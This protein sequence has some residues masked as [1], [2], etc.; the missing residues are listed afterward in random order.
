MSRIR[1]GLPYLARSSKGTFYPSFGKSNAVIF[2]AEAYKRYQLE[3]IS[4]LLA[5]VNQSAKEAGKPALLKATAVGMGFFAK[6]N[7]SYDIQ[8]LLFPYYLRAYKQ[9]LT[10]QK[11]P[12]I[13]KIEFPIFGELQQ[14]QF[15]AIFA[16]YNG[17]VK[18]YQSTRDVLAFSESETEKFLP[19]VINPSDAFSYIGNEWGYGSVE[20]M[21][22]NNSSLRLDQVPHANPLLLE[23][24]HHVGVQ[25]NDDYSVEF[26]EKHTLQSPPKINI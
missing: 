23:P 10:E 13:T 16:D 19:A 8:H 18:V 4:L 11:Y 9:L 24:S 17:H 1:I 6:I 25:I 12:W 22:G 14:E 20:S 5:S 26:A 15:D 7:C 21:I 2:L 3:D